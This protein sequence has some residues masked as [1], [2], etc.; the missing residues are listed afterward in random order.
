LGS[1][2]ARK[3]HLEAKRAFDRVKQHPVLNEDEEGPTVEYKAADGSIK[4]MTQVRSHIGDRKKSCYSSG[5]GRHSPTTCAVVD[6][7][8]SLLRIL[9]TLP[10]L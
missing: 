3:E 7:S 6:S 5:N 1:A 4:T 10:S 9:L 2:A 8:R